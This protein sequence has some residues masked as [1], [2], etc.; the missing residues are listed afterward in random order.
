M[1]THN[2]FLD[3]TA[4]KG[5]PLGLKIAAGNVPNFVDLQTGGWG[6]AIQ[7]PL[8]SNQTTTMANFATLAD[9]LSGCITRVTPDA[10][11]KLFAAATPPT[12]RAP[13]DTL[14]AAEAIAKNSSY[15]PERVFALLDDFYPVPQGKTL[16]PTPR[17]PLPASRTDRQSFCRQGTAPGC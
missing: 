14:A 12:G 11:S 6:A 2:Q 1:W 10:C 13:T 5:N 8:N 9:A 16:R 17:M 3:G 4:I 7:D 15:R